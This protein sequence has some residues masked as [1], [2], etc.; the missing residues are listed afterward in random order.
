MK[1]PNYIY[2]TS[3]NK[4]LSGIVCTSNPPKIICF[5]NEEQ[6]K[7]IIKALESQSSQ[8]DVTDEEIEKEIKSLKIESKG[9]D[10]GKEIEEMNLEMLQIGFRIGAKFVRSRQ[11]QNLR[12]E[13]IKFIEWLSTAADPVL[14]DNETTVDNYLN[15]K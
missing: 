10:L 8:A 5:C 1:T 7:L 2:S 13:L 4:G 9:I 11:Q 15:S 12:E 14:F 3:I 6:S